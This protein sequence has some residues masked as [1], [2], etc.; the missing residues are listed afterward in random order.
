VSPAGDPAALHDAAARSRT[1]SASISP[2]CTRGRGLA[3]RDQRAAVVARESRHARAAAMAPEIWRGWRDPARPRALPRPPQAGRAIGLANR[4]TR[5]C[6]PRA[7]RLRRP[8]LCS[9]PRI[10]RQS[11]TRGARP[12]PADKRPFE[13]TGTSL[14]RRQLSRRALRRRAGTSTQEKDNGVLRRL[15][16][17][18]QS[19]PG[20]VP[21]GMRAHLQGSGAFALAYRGRIALS[22]GPRGDLRPSFG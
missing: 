12:H 15:F 3:G 6:R 11:R 5:A 16:G 22:R 7:C 18:G 8:R 9:R 2:P 4:P 1:T 10:K 14:R 17:F 13:R 21:R 19:P 20:S